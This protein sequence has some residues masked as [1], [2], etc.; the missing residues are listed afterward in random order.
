MIGPF[1]VG[2]ETSGRTRDALRA[3]GIDAVSADI[4]PSTAPGP[5][6]IGDV[7][8]ILEGDPRTSA[9]TPWIGGLFHPTCTY[10][11]TSAAWAFNDPDFDRYPGVGYHQKVKADT[12]TGADRRRAREL[13][14]ADVERIAAAPFW[15]IIENPRGTIPTR[16]SLGA[17]CA[18]VNPFEFGDDASKATCLWAHDDRGRKAPLDIPRSAAQ[19][20]KP[21]LVCKVCGGTSRYD[22]AFGKGCVHCGA[23]AGLLL[24]RWS[25]Q[26]DSGQNRETVS[27][28]RWS[29]RSET[30]PG[31]ASALADLIVERFKK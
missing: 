29:V 17:P 14:E 15:K 28:D 5:H 24:P 19:Y 18:V 22:D 10:H 27:D 4:L 6:I 8:S 13:A 1:L 30:Y 31:I 9:F 21:R 3:R 2:M 20:V 23:E 11:V 16:T 25:N 26:T 12:L 7:F